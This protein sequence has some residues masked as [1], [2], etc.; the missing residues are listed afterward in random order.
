[1]YIVVPVSTQPVIYL[2][3][4]L[5]SVFRYSFFSFN[6]WISVLLYLSLFKIRASRVVYHRVTDTLALVR[7][8]TRTYVFPIATWLGNSHT[9]DLFMR[10]CAHLGNPTN[11]NLNGCNGFNGGYVRKTTK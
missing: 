11:F 6:T 7:G 8:G 10:V 4:A 2:Y 1:M 5:L 9:V 3:C